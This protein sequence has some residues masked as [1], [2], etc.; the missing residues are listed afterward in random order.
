MFKVKTLLFLLC[1]LFGFYYLFFFKIPWLCLYD[2]DAC[3]TLRLGLNA[4]SNDNKIYSNDPK[5]YSN[6]TKIHSNDTKIYSNDTKIYSNDTKIYSHDT[7]IYSNDTKI[8]YLVLGDS[9]AHGVFKPS[10]KVVHSYSYA[11]ALYER[12]KE[13]NP[14]IVLKKFAHGGH[15]T[16]KLISEQL[17]E[18]TKFMKHNRG[19]IKLVTIT[20]GLNDVERCLK[21]SPSKC[22]IRIHKIVNNLK[23]TIIP[24]LKK[25]GGKDVQYWAT[26][27]H[28]AH[29][30]LDQLSDSLIKVY[31]E[32]GFNVVDMRKIITKETALN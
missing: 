24:K 28:N 29:A 11:D 16:G 17:G 25:A 10:D 5:T 18:A 15:N 6:N 2:D 22:D 14:N 23:N 4:Q 31:R 20:I 3:R 32:N 30:N 13:T 7:K 1:I 27:Y 19:L 21:T 12:L 26:T 9:F 8:Y